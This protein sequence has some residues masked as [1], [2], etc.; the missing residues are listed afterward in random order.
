M[1]CDDRFSGKLK[2]FGKLQESWWLLNGRPEKHSYRFCNQQTVPELLSDWQ[3][4]VLLWKLMVLDTFFTVECALIQT[5][6]KRNPE[7]A[8]MKE[9]AH[10]QRHHPGRI[11]SSEHVLNTAWYFPHCGGLWF[12]NKRV[13]LLVSCPV[14]DQTTSLGLM[15]ICAITGVASHLPLMAIKSLVDPLKI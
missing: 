12:C 14:C 4:G 11:P 7:I 3:I 13:L 1:T 5:A 9:I 2:L 15:G 8:S 6:W 10:H